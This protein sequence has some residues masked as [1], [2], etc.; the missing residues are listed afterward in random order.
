MKDL[1]DIIGQ[2]DYFVLTSNGECHFEMSGFDPEKIDEIEGNWLTMQCRAAC[3]DTLYPVLEK[4]EEMHKAEKDGLVPGDLT[5]KCPK[6]GSPMDIHMMGAADR[7]VADDGGQRLGWRNQL[8]K[9]PLMRLTAAEPKATYITINLGEVYITEN[10]K[11][12]SYGIDGKIADVLREI[13]KAM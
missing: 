3:H 9:G 10:I 4:A 1:R 11:N 12:K 6:C 7:Y 13:K 2:K 8:I 5:P